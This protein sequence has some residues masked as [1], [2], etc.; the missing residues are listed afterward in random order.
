MKIFNGLFKRVLAGF[1]V[2]AL[3]CMVG[4]DNNQAKAAYT[5]ESWIILSRYSRQLNVGEDFLLVAVSC[6]DLDISMSSSNS[7]VASV[8]S[9]GRVLAM[10]PGKATITAKTKKAKA[11]CVVTVVKP[12]LTL[13][14]SSITLYRNQKFVIKANSTTKGRIE[15]RTSRKSVA[16]VD[17]SGVVTAIGNGKADITVTC[18]GVAKKCSVTVAKP[19]MYV[20]IESLNIREGEKRLLVA[21]V[22]SGNKPEWHSSNEDIVMVN[23]N[24]VVSARKKGYAYVYAVEDGVKIKIKVR[25]LD[26]QYAKYKA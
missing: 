24:G 8:S 25:V 3:L 13:N 15:F 17:S 11:T 6:D 16:T 22:S 7:K 4:I 20:D 26:S 10:R 5:N 2:C 12:Q 21:E 18:D 19:D 14:K 1:M 23:A 9:S